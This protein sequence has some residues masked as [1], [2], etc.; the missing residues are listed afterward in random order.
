[1]KLVFGGAY[2]G[3]LEYAMEA[4]EVSETDIY[5]CSE[6]NTDFPQAAKIV[7]ELDKWILALIKAGIDTDTAISD[8]MKNNTDTCI[9]ANDIS[10]GI[11]PYEPQLRQ[12]R[13]AVGRALAAIA[14]ESDEVVRLF[15]GIPTRLV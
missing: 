13:E 5:R 11:V 6:D 1:M 10:S 12:W 4:Y 9:I 14:K 2:Q 8:F 7:Y 15:C 3:K